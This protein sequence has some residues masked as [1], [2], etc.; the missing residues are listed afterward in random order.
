MVD[1]YPNYEKVENI[2]ESNS[3]TNEEVDENYR[4]RIREIPESF[5]TAGSSG[6]YT[7]WTKTASANIIDVKVHSPSATNVDIYIWTGTGTVSQE[8]KEKVETVLNH[9]NT[10]PLTDKVN[11]KEPFKIDYSVDFDYYI[12]KDDETLVNIIKSNVD[13]TIQ[14]YINWQKKKIGKD[15]N[16]DELIKRLKV[17]GVK[18]A[19]LRNPNFQKLDFNQIAINNGI[20][21]NYQG[22]EEL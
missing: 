9:E 6:A 1:I 13:K 22:V 10:R 11:I 3:G 21:I 7:F 4:E 18:R 20:T 14:E 5:T 19:V 2:T 16:P 17:A 8:L 15:I 12:D